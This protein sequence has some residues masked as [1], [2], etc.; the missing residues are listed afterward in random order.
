MFWC[1]F[2]PFN[3]YI[4][5]VGHK[6]GPIR[7]GRLSNS[8]KLEKR[9][10]ENQVQKVTWFISALGQ[11]EHDSIQWA[12]ALAPSPDNTY[13][14]CCGNWASPAAIPMWVQCPLCAGCQ[15]SAVQCCAVQQKTQVQL[16][17]LHSGVTSLLPPDSD[18]LD[19][20]RLLLLGFT[21]TEHLHKVYLNL[22]TR[23]YHIRMKLCWIKTDFRK[24]QIIFHCVYSPAGAITVSD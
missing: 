21:K 8:R 18:Q 24:S 9:S 12:Q 1:K 15:C 11:G 22:G 6:A 10:E 2:Q 5:G 23:P 4:L 16:S 7:E 13:W 14:F 17:L 3:W 20:W 19:I